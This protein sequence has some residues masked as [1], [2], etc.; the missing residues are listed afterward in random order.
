[1]T[2]LLDLLG[3]LRLVRVH[4][5]SAAGAEGTSERWFRDLAAALEG[6][7]GSQWC[8]PPRWSVV[9]GCSS[10]VGDVSIMAVAG[11]PSRGAGVINFA[12]W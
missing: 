10:L 7:C 4:I 11:E 1:M 5:K 8:R 3:A 12:W 9:A 2:W 6:V